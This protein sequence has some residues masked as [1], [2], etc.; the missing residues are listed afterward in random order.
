MEAGV[1]AQPVVRS[2]QAALVR[3]CVVRR[4]RAPIQERA[5]NMPAPQGTVILARVLHLE[6]IR[7]TESGWQ[8]EADLGGGVARLQ[9]GGPPTPG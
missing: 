5:R 1:G 6:V 3:K 8:K 9:E 7:E 4:T 2:S